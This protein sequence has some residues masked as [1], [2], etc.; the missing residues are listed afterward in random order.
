MA[1]VDSFKTDTPDHL[2]RPVL[3][4]QIKHC[5]ID[6]LVCVDLVGFDQGF[7]VDGVQDSGAPREIHSHHG[8]DA[9]QVFRK[10]SWP[11]PR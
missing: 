11:I 4:V 7:A 6:F 10:V 1:G 3:R 8:D 5:G 2:P 9:D